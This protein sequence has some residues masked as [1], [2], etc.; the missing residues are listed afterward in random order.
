MKNLVGMAICAT[1][2]IILIGSML[3]PAVSDLAE[4]ERTFTNDG[5]YPMQEFNVGDVWA[6]DST[7]GTWTL[8][9][10]SVTTLSDGHLIIVSNNLYIRDTGQVRSTAATGNAT[11]TTVT[12]SDS[13]I[14]ITG[15]GITGSATEY[16]SGWGV[17][18]EGD[19]IL[20]D[21][22]DSRSDD[23]VYMVSDS[24]IYGTDS[25]AIGDKYALVCVEGT[26]DGVTVTAHPSYNN[27]SFEITVSDVVI[28]AD[29][30]SGYVDLQTF[31]KVTFTLTATIDEEEVTATG[32]ISSIVTNGSVTAE[33]SEHMDTVEIAVLVVIPIMMIV[34][35]VVMCARV[36]SKD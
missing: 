32:A 18:G 20:V 10:E 33:L 22:I 36:V 35:M 29:E 27:G 7:E 12:I 5:L 16:T 1:V 28:D 4:T 9:D 30:V 25:V 2:G 8:N 24:M 6:R 19:Y 11:N 34:A 23:P 31:N 14:G 17:S 21:W 3:A 13:T 26:M 15:S